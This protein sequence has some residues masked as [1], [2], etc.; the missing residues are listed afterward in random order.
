MSK[1]FESI[2][3]NE[4][5]NYYICHNCLQLFHY[6]DLSFCPHE[7]D[8]PHNILA[9]CIPCDTILK[10]SRKNMNRAERQKH[11]KEY[12]ENITKN[13]KKS[14]DKCDDYTSDESTEDGK[15]ESSDE[16]CTQ[17][18]SSDEESQKEK[19]KEKSKKNPKNIKLEFWISL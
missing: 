7:K 6:S 16:E 2:P 18:E 11:M 17:D 3:S 15:N 12:L 9:C 13:N 5:E 4:L 19:E 14:E 1:N 8:D 10:E